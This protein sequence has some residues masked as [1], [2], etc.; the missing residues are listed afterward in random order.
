MKPS[1]LR[2]SE[3]SELDNEDRGVPLDL[4]QVAGIG[5]EPV[6]S[7]KLLIIGNNMF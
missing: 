5:F 1:S 2:H 4:D 7:F 6:M 3:L